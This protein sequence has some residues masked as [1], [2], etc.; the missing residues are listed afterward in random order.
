MTVTVFGIEESVYVRIVRLT[1]EVKGIMHRLSRAD[2]FSTAGLPAGYGAVHPFGRIPAI[3]H[4]GFVLYETA[5]ITRYLDEAF[6][7]PKLQPEAARARARMVQVIGVLDAYAYRCWVWDFHVAYRRA[8]KPDG[9]AAAAPSAATAARTLDA[10]AAIMDGSAFLAGTQE[11][12]LADLHAAPMMRY[13]MVVPAFLDLVAAR[14]PLHAW[15]ERV[16]VLPSVRAICPEGQAE[17]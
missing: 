7:G 3:D 17:A 12:T 8:G 9:W 2:P 10:L 15:W 14:P 13:G 16:S 5:A 1:L 11:P 6:D 4:D